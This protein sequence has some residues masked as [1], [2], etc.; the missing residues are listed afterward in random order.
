MWFVIGELRKNFEFR[1]VTDLKRKTKA[2]FVTR[3]AFVKAL[4]DVTLHRYSE[5]QERRG[6]MEL[7]NEQ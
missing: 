5:V 1:E 6:T 2:Y 4:K 3:E 7:E